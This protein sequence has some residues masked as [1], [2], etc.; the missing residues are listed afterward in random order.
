MV[1]LVVAAAL[2]QIAPRPNIV[3]IFSDDHARQAISAYGSTLVET[4]NLDRLAQEGL[5]F[6]RHYTANP[7]CAP[8]RATLLTGKYSHGNGIRDNAS[9]FDG[10][11]DTFPKM[12]R[13]AGYRTAVIGKWHLASEPTGF[14]HWDILP[15]QGAYYNPDFLTPRGKTTERGYATE[16]VTRK[17][18]DWL[19]TNDKGPFFLLVGHK[20]PH[21]TWIPGP[22]QMSLFS[23]RTYPEPPTL[24][25]DYATLT[26]AART[27]RMRLDEHIRP[28]EDLLVDFVPPRMDGAQR[29]LWQAAMAKQDEAYKRALAQSGDLLGTNYQRY[30]RDYLRCVAGLD[31]SVGEIYG[32][33]RSEGLLKNTVVI[34]ASDQGFFLGENGW[35]DKRWFYEPSAGTPLVIRPPGEGRQARQVP[36][37]TS[38]VDLAPTIL[39]LAGVDVP[40]SMQG[41]T[42]APIV[43]GKTIESGEITVYGHFYESDDPDHK[44]PKYVA[45]AT[46]R[47]KLIF[48][49]E[50]GEWEMFDLRT[51]PHETRNLWS[52][53]A[54][55]AVRSEL[56]RK[57]LAKQ[58]ELQEEPEVV[59]VTKR[60]ASAARRD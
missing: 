39:E 19:R 60:A 46:A 35:Y 16:I 2:L 17:A 25:T 41:V 27:V 4:P 26:S 6:D 12:L 44:A 23:D 37:L 28:A 31:E 43:A 54:T 38:N 34:Y 42:L 58:R 9:V 47:H 20:T 3:M 24:R 57:L 1:G 5:R 40:D 45:I 14:D 53:G 11:Q 10:T 29:A 56:V 49:Y 8:S 51:D 22:K 18:L 52:D 15:G 36:S 13:E 55:N 7:I 32:Y 48:Y 30:L 33:L 21:R 50:L 59:R